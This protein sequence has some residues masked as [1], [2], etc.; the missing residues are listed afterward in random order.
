MLFA[1]AATDYI[2]AGIAFEE[3]DT[4]QGPRGTYAA[5]RAGVPALIPG[6]GYGVLPPGS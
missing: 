5:Y 6:P 3:H 4:I 2:L 1:A